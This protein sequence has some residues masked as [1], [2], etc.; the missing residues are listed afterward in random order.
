M[1]TTGHHFRRS[2]STPALAHETGPSD[3]PSQR[4]ADRNAQLPE[5][6]T[7]PQRPASRRPRRTI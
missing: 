2:A 3:R 1:V 5:H 7:R 4:C 6:R